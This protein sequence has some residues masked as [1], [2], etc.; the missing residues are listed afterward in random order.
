MKKQEIAV[1]VDSIVVCK[2]KEDFKVLL[3]QRKNDPYKNQWALP[4]GFVEENESLENAA[5]RELAEETGLTLKTMQQIRAFGKP[6][7]DPRMRT[8]SIAF[9]GKITEEKYLRPADD[10]IAAKWV[11]FK[12]LADLELAFDHANIIEEAKKHL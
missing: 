10:A 4:G 12:K 1:T 7:R 3:I 11:S 5:R 2:A 8:I 9:L 6:N